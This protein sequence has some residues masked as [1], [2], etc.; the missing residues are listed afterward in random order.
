MIVRIV[1]I[2]LVES[3]SFGDDPDDWDGWWFR[4][5]RLD[6][7]EDKRR[8]VVSDVS[9][10]DNGNFARASQ[11]SQTYMGNANQRMNLLACCLLILSILRRNK[12]EM[13]HKDTASTSIR[14]R[15]YLFFRYCPYAVRTFL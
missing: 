6:R 14:S 1:L 4:Y 3:K 10:Y 13:Y 8:G 12:V 11:T 5:N 2:A 7:F 9:G 15:E